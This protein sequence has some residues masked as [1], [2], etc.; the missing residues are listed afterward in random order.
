MPKHRTPTQLRCFATTWTRGICLVVWLIAWPAGQ[1]LAED[2]TAA[3]AEPVAA[4]Q[5]VESP[6]ADPATD[7][8][9]EPDQPLSGHSYHGEAFNRGPRQAAELLPGM[10]NID[11]PSSAREEQTQQFINQGVAALHGFWYLEAERSFRQAATL[12]P[13]LG[14][15]YWGM[16]MANTNNSTRAR[17]FIENAK[18]RRGEATR[19]EQMYIDA[20][21]NFLSKPEK[22]ENA[23]QKKK[24]QQQ[25]ID[26]LEGILNEF[27]D[28][29]EA[30]AL[31]ALQLWQ[32]RLT[33]PIASN[34]AVNALMSE[35][36]AVNPLHP[37]HHYRIHLWDG[38]RPA[39]ALASAALCGQS[40]P[41]I[42]HMWHMPGH[43]Y[44]KLHRYEDAIWQQEASARTDHAHM[45]RARL[46]PDQIHNFSHNNEWLVRNLIFLGRVEEALRQSEDLL[47]MPRHPDYNSL[48]KRG[49]YRLGRTRLLQTLTEFELWERL[50]EAGQGPLL[51][52]TTDDELL[53]EHR[54]WMIVAR[55]LSGNADAARNDLR[56][57]HRNRLKLETEVLDLEEALD[58]VEE[59]KR[60][61]DKRTGTLQ[62]TRSKLDSLKQRIAL[63]ETA[64]AV[65]AKDKSA[66]DAAIG[67]AGKVEDVLAA[68]WRGQAGDRDGAIEALKKLA[69]QRTN[70]VRPL[71][72]LIDQLWQADKQDEAV[73]R[74][75]TLRK[76]A[77]SADLE[78]PL[79][80]RLRP[81]A[82]KAGVEGD[83][84]IPHEPADDIGERPELDTLGPR[85]W[86]SYLAPRWK[87]H[88]ADDEPIDDDHYQGKPKVLIFYLGFGCL[89]CVEQLKAFQPKVAEFAAQGIEVVGI[90][91][92]SVAELRKGIETYGEAAPLPLLADPDHEAFK[93]FRCWDDFENLP[94]HGTFLIDAD[95]RV[96]WQD[97]SYE[98]F[99]QVDFLL[100]ES[101]RLLAIP[102]QR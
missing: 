94:L 24:R 44:S 61:A 70:Q 2:K 55:T 59:D 32:A 25:Y 95:G 52:P 63:C 26:A 68:S 65:A 82:D 76:L 20:L 84:R 37:A 91:T 67:K 36:F 8:E 60:K 62:K 23:E 31:L 43:I 66:F 10:G 15:A 100:D 41:G 86:S 71:A 22:S 69:D 18:Q 16:A 54:Q 92:E 85:F 40:L 28:D 39:N 89:H 102:A 75:A 93:A 57:F 29:I 46:M 12:Q 48:T 50:V 99:S 38:P 58:G 27:P 96:R 11:F 30:R 7:A 74:F 90:S 13:D 17:E 87:A 88:T 56:S 64:A 53:D 4:T 81:V 1:S 101:R 42:A 35:V 34:H 80:A 3:T 97:I 14:I 83:W 98:P 21:A 79:L 45:T 6:A 73:E 51:E 9:A 19:R 72:I 49:S 33:V 78:T 47:A 77:G 5:A